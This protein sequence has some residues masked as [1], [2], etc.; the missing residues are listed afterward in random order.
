MVASGDAEASYEIPKD[1]EPECF[2]LEWRCEKA[3]DGKGGGERESEKT[4]PVDVLEK[5]C[6][7]DGRQLRG[8]LESVL[9][10]VVWYV[11][12]NR[13]ALFVRFRARGLGWST[14]RHGRW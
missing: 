12:V 6:S 11:Q 4:D 9:D 13:H 5:S 7:S 14:L 1:G 2:S 10:I 8:C 3:I